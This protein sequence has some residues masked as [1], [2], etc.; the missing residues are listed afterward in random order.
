[1]KKFKLRDQNIQANQTNQI[2][3]SNQ[4]EFQTAP[5]KPEPELVFSSSKY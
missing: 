2:E 5:L 4:S 1:V 3:K